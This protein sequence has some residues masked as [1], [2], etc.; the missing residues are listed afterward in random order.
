M[1]SFSS[2]MEVRQRLCEVSGCGKFGSGLSQGTE[3]SIH[4]SLLERLWV[5]LNHKTLVK[6]HQNWQKLTGVEERLV[7]L[8][9]R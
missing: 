1:G 7:M 9:E 8:A 6:F 4:F 5:L 3:G 2:V